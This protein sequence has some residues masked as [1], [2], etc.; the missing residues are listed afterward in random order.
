MVVYNFKQIEVVPT[1]KDFIDVTLSKTQRKTPTVVHK[2]YSIQRIRQFYM[3]KVKYTQATYQEK[4]TKIVSDF[5]R[6]DDIH[7]FYA[8]LSNVLYDRDHYKLALAQLNTARGLMDN[9]S[10]DYLRM[11]KYA[12]SLYRAKQLKRAALGRM[13]TIAKKLGPSLTYLEQVRQHMSRLPS[14][15]PNTRTL[16]LC[17]YPNVGK[18]SFMNKVTR[19]NVDVQPYAF[20]TKSLFVGHMDYKYLR[21][22]VID[23][24]GIL[25]HPLE[26]RN[27]IEMQAV[28]ALAHLRAAILYFVDVSE[29]CGFTIKEQVALFH[30]IKPLF[31]GK[32]LIVV[33]SKQ[34]VKTVDQLGPEDQELVRTMV[35][36][37]T[38]MLPASSMSEV[39]V[40]TVKNAACDKL[41]EQ[42]VSAKLRGKDG[43]EQEDVV[44]LT[45]P[46]PR[47]QRERPAIVPP[48]IMQV[49]GAAPRKLQKE[50]MLEQG[51]AGV[52]SADWRAQYDLK[53]DE[54]K[55]DIIPEIIDGKNIADFVDPEIEAALDELEREEAEREADIDGMEEEDDA[56]DAET[57]ATVAAIRTKKTLLI[58][59]HRHAKNNNRSKVPRNRGSKT[60]AEM[61]KAMASVG[62]DDEARVRARARSMDSSRGR[63]KSRA[64]SKTRGKDGGDAMM[65]EGDASMSKKQQKRK[66]SESR[67]A[68]SRSREPGVRQSHSRA[69]RSQSRDVAG[70]KDEGAK[71]KAEKIK[72]KKQFQMNKRARQGEADRFDAPKLTK[73][74]LVGKRGKG[75]TDRR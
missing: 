49:E 46:K 47:D 58:N 26:E 66:R 17:G 36:A 6:L 74:L 3:R 13:C 52:Y 42:R 72:R 44:R 57:E 39:G 75:K 56:L 45:I 29:Q 19:A 31:G 70:L 22:Q 24:P 51:G 25:D 7:P 32:P 12:D 69:P 67:T 16:I 28:T 68:G 15:D 1:A 63:S 30:S 54:W 8:D 37:E 10:A 59:A 23:T 11:M 20:T 61:E 33:A 71:I 43:K 38:Q 64:A 60:A 40:D 35:D 48:I 73:H 9:L 21:W 4:L 18:S 65:E 34:D 55:Y 27:T 50:I 41:L 5:P 14:I 2:G 53:C 62:Y